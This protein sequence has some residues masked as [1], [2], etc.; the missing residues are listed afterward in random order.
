MPSSNFSYAAGSCNI[1]PE[2]ISRRRNL[3]WVSSVIVLLLFSVLVWIGVNPWW[4]LL[5]FV[6]ATMA[7][8]GFLQ[9]YF[10][11]CSG[12]ARLGV[13]NFG[14]TGQR[15]EIA[16]EDSKKKDRKRGLEITVYAALIGAAITIFSIVFA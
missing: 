15:H 14:P 7:A 1:G 8:S 16:D 3:G 4:R 13:Y 5:I 12:F 10:R 9:A 6:P 2:E 11:F